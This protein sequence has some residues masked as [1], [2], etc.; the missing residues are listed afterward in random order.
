MQKTAG[1]DPD[2][3]PGPTLLMKLMSH[4]HIQYSILLKGS[5][6]DGTPLY[7]RMGIYHIALPLGLHAMD[8]PLYTYSSMCKQ[9]SWRM[10][11]SPGPSLGL[12]HLLQ[13]LSTY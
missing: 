6:L 11:S 10:E 8:E 3:L 5:P 2:Q 7:L 13:P 9:A 1:V 12:S 4:T